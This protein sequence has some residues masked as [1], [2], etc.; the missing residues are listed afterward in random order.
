M[1]NFNVTLKK[2]NATE[3]KEGKTVCG[4]SLLEQGVK[5]QPNGGQF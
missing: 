2:C 5:E 4:M 3:A 1:Y